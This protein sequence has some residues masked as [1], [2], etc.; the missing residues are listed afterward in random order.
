MI[1][2]SNRMYLL[3]KAYFIHNLY[4]KLV[5][6]RNNNSHKKNKIAF[7]Q[8]CKEL[9]FTYI[10]CN[11][12]D[13][14]PKDTDL[15]WS[16]NT[17]IDPNSVPEKT[18]IMFGPGFG[19]VFAYPEHPIFYYNYIG[20][21][22]FNLL[23]SWNI[24]MQNEFIEDRRISFVACPFPVDTNKFRPLV[25]EN[26]GQQD[27]DVL[28]YFKQRDKKILDN[29]KDILSIC[30]IS[31]HLIEYGNYKE[32][33]YIDLLKKSKLC[34][35][36]GCHESQGFAFQ[37]C[38]SMNVPILCYDVQ[39]M[40]DEFGS[41]D[42]TQFC[43]YEKYKGEKNLFATSATSWSPKCGEK[44]HN[45]NEIPELIIKMLDSLDSYEPREFIL[46]NLSSEACWK[47]WQAA[48]DL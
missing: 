27:I 18:K 24:N 16:D 2:F 17:V 47:K 29:L 35:W 5:A 41:K 8:M 28:I 48:L 32:D 40:F 21:V 36:V 33:E 15:I 10:E 14:I 12:L 6:F 42:D 45:I 30:P 11:S 7:S 20:K 26:Q 23:S 34:L 31:I 4:M 25:A 44:T 43:C 37:E 46:E 22:V 13:E 1:H 3:P 19:F 39:S 38:L 9:N